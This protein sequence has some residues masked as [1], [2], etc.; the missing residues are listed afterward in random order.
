MFN[1]P[2]VPHMGGVWERLVRS[3]KKALDVVLQNQ[4][5]TDELLLTTFA[6]V[7]WLV[8]S[9]PL[10]EVSSDVDDFEALALALALALYQRKR[11]SKLATSVFV[12]REISS[13]KRWRQ[14]H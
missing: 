7:E 6:E 14:A 2:A 1:P 9:R 13:H 5:L 10:T 12:D 4:V 3:C 8:N 11:N